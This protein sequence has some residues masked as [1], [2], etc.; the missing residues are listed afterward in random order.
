M[1]GLYKFDDVFTKDQ[2]VVVNAS[3]SKNV[4]PEDLIDEIEQK[5]GIGAV[6][7]C[8]P[9][10]G[11]GYEIVLKERKHVGELSEDLMIRG[12]RIGVKEL[13]SR[14]RI[15]SIIN[16]SMYV[17]DEEIIDRFKKIGV[18]I[19]S[20][21]KKRKMP[22]RKSVYDGTRIFKAQLPPTLASIPYSMKFSVDEKETA[23]YRVVHNEQVKVCSGCFSTDH[24]YK[25]CPDFVCFNCGQQGHI[26]RHCPEKR[27]A[28][29]G[30]LKTLC[31]CKR[32]RRWGEG[33]APDFKRQNRNPFMNNRHEDVQDAD[34]NGEYLGEERNNDWG[35]KYDDANDGE[36]EMEEGLVNT[37]ENE[38][39]VNGVGNDG[40][41]VVEVE[42]HA[43]EVT[44][45]IAEEPESGE[46]ASG[47]KEAVEEQSEVVPESQKADNEP[48]LEKESTE[49]NK[50]EL[51]LDLNDDV[52]INNVNKNVDIHVQENESVAVNS[53][54][55]KNVEVNSPEIKN[56]DVDSQENNV[57]VKN[58]TSCENH[59]IITV[60]DE[61][62]VVENQ[63]NIS[64]LE[65]TS[66]Q[67]G[68]E[69]MEDEGACGKL[70][71]ISLNESSWVDIDS[72]GEI[73]VHKA[74]ING[75]FK[76]ISRRR[77]KK[78]V[79][80]YKAAKIAHESKKFKAQKCIRK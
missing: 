28:E 10:Q 72:Q 16:L 42:V 44:G 58:T 63:N 69:N 40:P 54:E 45:G 24:I 6:L 29:C 22:S 74:D 71:D 60:V 8:V 41:Q 32:K 55:N 62:D 39:E 4:T 19:I 18:E 35:D 79:P 80:N 52:T 21:I 77:M 43:E 65:Q 46:N 64:S 31:K 33:F 12:K 78:A 14:V 27:C 57:I 37:D 20:E 75:S 48:S 5:C 61:T 15:V 30:Y 56:V 59:D 49:E 2:T 25:D 67:G 70:D 23:Y 73:N 7:A 13:S 9:K 1:A 17:T 50:Q 34:Q 53:Q 38:E 47:S 11:S 76:I 26:G 51:V 3:D 68:D 66:S 36:T